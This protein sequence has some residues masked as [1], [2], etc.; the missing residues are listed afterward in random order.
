[1]ELRGSIIVQRFKPI[2]SACSQ[3]HSHLSCGLRLRNYVQL[4][5]IINLARSFRFMR[6]FVVVIQSYE[7]Q[8]TER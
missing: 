5:E 4:R 7:A 2:L 6:V 3:F 1:M 8:K